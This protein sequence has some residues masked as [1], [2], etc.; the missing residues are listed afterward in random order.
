MSHAV[1][2]VAL[3]LDDRRV[4]LLHTDETK[5]LAE[6][7]TLMVSARCAQARA[8]PYFAD[9]DELNEPVEGGT[10]WD[11]LSAADYDDI[12][13]DMAARRQAGEAPPGASG[14]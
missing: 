2:T 14:A 5:D 9:D 8:D 11:G 3:H 10:E 6:A 12:E 4:L 13:R 7:I 1:A